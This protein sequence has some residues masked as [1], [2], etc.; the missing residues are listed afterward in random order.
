MIVTARVS[1]WMPGPKYLTFLCLDVSLLVD[2]S[3]AIVPC[4]RCRMENAIMK[5]ILS[6]ALLAA[7]VAFVPTLASANEWS[8]RVNLNFGQPGY[9]GY[10]HHHRHGMRH[11]PSVRLGI[12]CGGFY[13]EGCFPPRHG[14][15]MVPNGPVPGVVGT[16][17]V[18][19]HGGPANFIP[20]H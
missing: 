5:T 4:E 2:S 7:I 6:A 14:Y 11:P 8:G 17:L 15:V 13:G 16:L 12:H 20:R 10:G 9:G 1:T 19:R 3:E 18:P